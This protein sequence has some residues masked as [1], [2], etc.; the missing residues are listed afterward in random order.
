M[1]ERKL[2]RRAWKRE[3][4]G[5]SEGE[6]RVGCDQRWGQR[7]SRSGGR[8]NSVRVEGRKE[9]EE[10]TREKTTPVGAKVW[11]GVWCVG[12][13]DFIDSGGWS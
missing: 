8:Q 9:V 6:E 11:T 12:V 1:E 5:G 2:Q 7:N 13:V 10:E 4:E 3:R